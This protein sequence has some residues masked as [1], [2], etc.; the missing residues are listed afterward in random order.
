[1]AGKHKTTRPQSGG[2]LLTIVLC[3]DVLERLVIMYVKKL[4]IRQAES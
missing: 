4:R 3:V 1:M 2:R